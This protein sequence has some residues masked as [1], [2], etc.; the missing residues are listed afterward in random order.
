MRNLGLVRKLGFGLPL[1]DSDQ[2]PCFC[3]GE[4]STLTQVDQASNCLHHFKAEGC[5]R[6]E[7]IIGDN[8]NVS[9]NGVHQ[10]QHVSTMGYF[11]VCKKSGE[12]YQIIDSRGGLEINVS[13]L[14]M[15]L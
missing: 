14:N 7:D 15:I 10:I 13:N 5:H 1:R 9:L 6:K 3:V 12:F 2:D 8:D 11:F 4:Q